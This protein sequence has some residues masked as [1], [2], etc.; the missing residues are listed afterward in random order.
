[1]LLASRDRSF[2]LWN[3]QTNVQIANFHGLDA[4]REDVISIDFNGDCSKIITSGTDHKIIIWDLMTPEISSA[5]ETSK[6][7]KGITETFKTA[8]HPFAEFATRDVHST[9]VDCV[10]WFGDLVI[11]KVL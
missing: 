7:F 1:M 8:Y 10:Q 9:Y 11:S 2:R 5:I 4:H 3:L 6:S